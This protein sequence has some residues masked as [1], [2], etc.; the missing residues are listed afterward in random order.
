MN[1]HSLTK[2][3]TLTN[4]NAEENNDNQ[5]EDAQFQQDEFT[6]P[7]CTPVREVV[8][9]SLRNIGNSNLY[10]FNQPQDSE[11][12]GLY[13][14]QSNTPPQFE[15]EITEHSNSCKIPQ[16]AQTIVFW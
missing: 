15:R 13:K 16:K 12:K 2:P 4:V 11:Y 9:S 1:I 7:F 6:N 10:T 3:S 14:L 5:A 8:E